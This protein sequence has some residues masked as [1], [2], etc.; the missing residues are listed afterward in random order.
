M[1]KALQLYGKLKNRNNE[2]IDN[3]INILHKKDID[4]ILYA[5]SCNL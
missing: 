2:L 5:K 3:D 1:L 4:E